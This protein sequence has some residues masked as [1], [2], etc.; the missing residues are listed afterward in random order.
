VKVEDIKP[1]NI[2]KINFN[3]VLK[4]QKIIQNNTVKNH[5]SHK[6]DAYSNISIPISNLLDFS[7]KSILENTP[8]L[9][10]PLLTK[11][12]LLK[13]KEF[14][15]S[16]GSSISQKELEAMAEKIASSLK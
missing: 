7:P 13:I 16:D 4:A 8:E 12:V 5:F 10:L 9:Y 3:D 15:P 2:N 11:K 6:E 1:I 14:L